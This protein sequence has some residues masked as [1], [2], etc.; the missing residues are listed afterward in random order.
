MTQSKKDFKSD[1]DYY[2]YLKANGNILF[3]GIVGS[4]AY[5]T[6][7]ATSDEDKNFVYIQPL[8]DLLAGRIV[9]QL[10]IGGDDYVGYE[11]SRY[12]ELLQTANPNKLDYLNMPED[13]IITMHPMFQE[14]VVN[15]KHLFITKKCRWSYGEYAAEQIRKARGLNKKISNPMPVEKKNVLDFCW[16]GHKQGSIGIVEYL[17]NEHGV[18]PEQCGLV[19]IEHMKNCY[20]VFYGQ[21]GVYKGIVQDKE[22]SKT[23]SL[24]SVPKG[25][26]PICMMYHNL[27][28]Y[29]TYCREYKEYHDW[30]AKRNPERYK[31]NIAN[32]KNYDAK[33]MMHCHRLLDM[34]IEIADTGQVN[35]RRKDKQYLLDIRAG[36]E[37]YELLVAM[38]EYKI[39]KMEIAY[40]ECNLP[41]KCDAEVVKD[42]LLKM[43]LKFYFGMK[44]LITVKVPIDS[45]DYTINN[46]GCLR[47]TTNCGRVSSCVEPVEMNVYLENT[48]HKI[49]GSTVLDNTKMVVIETL[50]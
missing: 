34:A 19:A 47:Y 25:E 14:F 50:S 48:K 30:V 15:N 6:N 4:T 45:D 18:T 13:C 40:A 36:K 21:P 23:V 12:L 3:E 22:T 31:A 37:S 28:G 8:E 35:V 38:A 2:N 33:N 10:N 9:Q 27:E 24:S 49:I 16:V 46:V 42:I 11:I 17:D 5:G 43:R 29:S 41:E 1:E 7:I 26:K 20:H 44:N 39:T 32:E